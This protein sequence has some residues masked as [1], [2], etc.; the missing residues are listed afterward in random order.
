ME[1]RAALARTRAWV[2]RMDALDRIAA[3]REEVQKAD[4]VRRTMSRDALRSESARI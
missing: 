2:L 1:L 4:V 3:L